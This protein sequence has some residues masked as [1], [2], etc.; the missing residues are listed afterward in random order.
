LRYSS[1][2]EYKGLRPS[3]NRPEL[4]VAC[5]QTAFAILPRT[6]ACRVPLPADI[7]LRAASAFPMFPLHG[8]KAFIPAFAPQGGIGR[9]AD[10]GPLL[11]ARKNLRNHA[12]FF[13]LSER[14]MMRHPTVINITGVISS[15][16]RPVPIGK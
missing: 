8:G 16:S 13:I 1:T 14:R 4:R 6:L 15:K 2:I 10:I 3:E 9:E 12:V 5:F 7:I 11:L